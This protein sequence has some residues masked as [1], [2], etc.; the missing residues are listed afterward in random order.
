MSVVHIDV[1]ELSGLPD[2]YVPEDGQ[3]WL[4]PFLAYV[5][6]DGDDV[7]LTLEVAPDELRLLS[8]VFGDEDACGHACI[9]QDRW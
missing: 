2:N 8:I 4:S 9:L 5:V 1:R 6:D 7:P 3:V